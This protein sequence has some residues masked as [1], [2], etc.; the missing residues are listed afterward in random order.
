MKKKPS[1]SFKGKKSA[2]AAKKEGI[3]LADA[4]LA[5]EEYGARDLWATAL[6]EGSKAIPPAN[7]RI[8]IA[9]SAVAVDAAGC[10]YNPDRELH[11][12]AV[13]EAVAA[14]MRKIH[15]RDLQPSAP[16]RVV[17]Y[18]PEDDELELLLEDAIEDD[19]E[20]DGVDGSGGEG[21]AAWCRGKQGLRKKNK[22]DRNREVR[23]REIEKGIETRR[24]VKQ[25]RR[26][27]SNLKLVQCQVED[28]LAAREERRRRRAADRAEKAISQPPKL[29]KHTF[30]PLPVQV[31]TT[32]EL[33]ES[34]GSLR[35]LKPTAM[36]AKERF[37]SL[38]RRGLIE[39]RRK[40]GK[41]RGKKIEYVHGQ[42]ADN[43]A[44][45]QAEVETVRENARKGK[46]SRNK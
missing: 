2:H 18:T 27:L 20:E 34:K 33:E 38:Q 5:Q 37:K 23:N 40:V 8:K 46:K 17:D 32:E 26:D 1:M 39:P 42:R 10:S 6:V 7:K 12:D 36:L 9:A 19:E 30:E 24:R 31:L 21:E 14:E 4:S 13:A 29:G 44:Q 28:I 41:S 35:Q 43:A 16:L 25:Q 3:T 22:T 11:Q 45:R 15:D